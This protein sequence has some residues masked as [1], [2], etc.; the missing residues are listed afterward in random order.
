VTGRGEPGHAG[1]PDDSDGS[2]LEAT[3]CDVQERL[4]FESLPLG[5]VGA[6]Q[7]GLNRWR[8][9]QPVEVD[10][11]TANASQSTLTTKT[12]E[13]LTYAHHHGYQTSEL[14]GLIK[15]LAR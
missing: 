8:D 14:I 11:V 7:A 3:G 10:C 9:P 15:R 6:R 1:A 13:L 5:E 2:R 12:Q 4:V